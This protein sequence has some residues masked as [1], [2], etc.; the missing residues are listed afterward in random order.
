MLEIQVMR[1][2]ALSLSILLLGTA[3]L[4]A[5]FYEPKPVVMEVPRASALLP[6]NQI[7][8]PLEPDD[9]P[10]ARDFAGLFLCLRHSDGRAR[11][12]GYYDRARSSQGILGMH[13]LDT[14]FFP[15]H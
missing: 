12:A 5:Y 2:R 7:T 9:F 8:A 3:G 10:A 11:S 13:P 15:P 6:T 14:V 1:A 4:L